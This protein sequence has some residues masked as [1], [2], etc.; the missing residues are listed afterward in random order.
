MTSAQLNHLVSEVKK[1]NAKEF[2]LFLHK[3]DY[4]NSAQNTE[5]I[6]VEDTDLSSVF[7]LWKNRDISPQTIRQKAWTRSRL[8]LA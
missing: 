6:D 2:L 1:L 8:Q 4:F 3:I 7:G 5:N